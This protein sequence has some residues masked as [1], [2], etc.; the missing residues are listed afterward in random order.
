[1]EKKSWHEW[2][3]S[4]GMVIAL[5][6][7]GVTFYYQFLRTPRQL[8]AIAR[9]LEWNR[10][11]GTG[12]V[13]LVIWNDGLRDEIL[14]SVYVKTSNR[15][16]RGGLL[17]ERICETEVIRPGEAKTLRCVA[18]MWSSHGVENVEEAA[19]EIV[20]KGV[21]LDFFVV[22]RNGDFL[23]SRV[24]TKLAR[25]ERPGPA[26]MIYLVSRSGAVDLLSGT[27]LGF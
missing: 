13:K 6:L 12:V 5:A 26:H 23:Q 1:M 3:N 20:A 19:A 7:A 27:R 9:P 21:I 22:D 10:V 16:V 11:D 15:N 8:T 14:E 4:L 24:I 2:L 17:S 25:L 18:K